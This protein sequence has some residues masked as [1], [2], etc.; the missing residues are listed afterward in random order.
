[1]VQS[2]WLG[3]SRTYVLQN[4]Q[5]TIDATNRVVSYT[6]RDPHHTRVNVVFLGTHLTSRDSRLESG[7]VSIY[8]H[9]AAVL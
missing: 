8:L 4:D 7:V 1:M 5:R 3:R 6:R 9:E 2:V